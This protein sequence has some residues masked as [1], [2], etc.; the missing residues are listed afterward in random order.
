MHG[1]QGAEDVWAVPS[2]GGVRGH[3]CG[4][5]DDDDVLILIKQLHALH[6]SGDRFG[7]TRVRQV[8]LE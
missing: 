4:L 7:G 5:V 6:G 2:H 3:A 1:F 8:D